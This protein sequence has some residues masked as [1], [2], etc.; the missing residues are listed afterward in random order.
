MNP[1]G[2]RFFRTLGRKWWVAAILAMFALISVAA[3]FL[4]ADESPWYRGAG[5]VRHSS[6]TLA[7]WSSVWS[8]PSQDVPVAGNRFGELEIEVRE[9]DVWIRRQLI[10]P[11]R[12]HGA[13]DIGASVF[14]AGSDGRAVLPGGGELVLE[15]IGVSLPSDAG[16]FRYFDPKTLETI[17]LRAEIAS[18]P[19]EAEV[20]GNFP[21]IRWVITGSAADRF[22]GN[23]RLFDARTEFLLADRAKLRLVERAVCLLEMEVPIWHNAPLVLNLEIPCGEPVSVLLPREPGAQIVAGGVRFQFVAS[24]TGEVREVDR[25]GEFW[26]RTP[27]DSVFVLGRISPRVWA[28]NCAIRAES[29]VVG[30]FQDVPRI[31]A[32]ELSAFS[33]ENLRFEWY[34]QVGHVGFEIVGLPGVPEGQS[35]G[36]LFDVRLPRVE[37]GSFDGPLHLAAVAA[38]ACEL[39]LTMSPSRGQVATYDDARVFEDVTPAELLREVL[40]D[41]PDRQF[42]IRGSTLV[43]EPRQVW[44]EWILAI[45]RWLEN[46]GS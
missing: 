30:W 36:N 21:V 11:P 18:C 33:G 44:P 7:T 46:L 8:P 16:E 39:E 45:E 42:R 9:A 13:R 10:E 31:Q 20:S 19:I 12:S 32:A 35:P 15:S 24:G 41:M 40:Q 4:G 25:R 22:R 38:K 5:A 6:G 2:G 3:V 26:A 1:V 43:F 27:T 34:P 14:R 28:A 17:D 37:F 29:G 23:F